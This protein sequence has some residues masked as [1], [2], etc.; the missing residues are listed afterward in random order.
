[1][2]KACKEWIPKGAIDWQDHRLAMVLA[3]PGVRL[4]KPN[5]LVIESKQSMTARGV[6]SPD[7][8]DAFC[9]AFAM[10]VAPKPRLRLVPREAVMP[11]R[12]S[13]LSA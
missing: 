13:W 8:A 1:M 7:R 2:W 9:L 11:T 4:N 10:P 5:R 3:S 6:A 12:T